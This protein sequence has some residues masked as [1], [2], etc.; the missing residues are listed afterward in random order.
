MR[1]QQWKPYK[2]LHQFGN[3][4]AIHGTAIY[5]TTMVVAMAGLPWADDLQ[6]GP[7]DDVHFNF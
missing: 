4:T 2:S 1:H 7:L 3:Y 6:L 5:G